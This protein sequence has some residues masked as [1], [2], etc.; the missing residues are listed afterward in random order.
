MLIL[1]PGLGCSS[2]SQPSTRRLPWEM[3]LRHVALCRGTAATGRHHLSQPPP[4]MEGQNDPNTRCTPSCPLGLPYPCHQVGAVN[5]QRGRGGCSR[6]QSSPDVPAPLT[7]EALLHHEL[8]QLNAAAAKAL[9]EGFAQVLCHVG[10]H[11]HPHLINQG[12]CTHGEAEASGEGVQ[13]LGVCA[14]LQGETMGGYSGAKGP[15]E[16]GGILPTPPRDQGLA[17]RGVPRSTR[18]WV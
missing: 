2:C 10:S 15:L 12:G 16:P 4:V 17:G 9:A 13:L 5:R 7:Q 18:T 1:Q 3:A 14:F 6:T 8:H 11:V